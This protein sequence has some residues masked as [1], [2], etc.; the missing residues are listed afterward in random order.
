M[1]N[2]GILVFCVLSSILLIHMLLT[3]S[4][5]AWVRDSEFL[6][7]CKSGTLQEVNDAIIEGA[8]VNARSEERDIT[9]L[10]V[11]AGSNTNS[12]VI[13]A[14]IQA[15]ADI[16]K[17]SNRNETPLM[18][19]AHYNL[20]QKAVAAMI[21]TLYQ[22]GDDVNAKDLDGRTPLLFAVNSTNLQAVLSLLEYGADAT[23]RDH[24]GMRPLDIA[25]TK[26]AFAGT[27]AMRKLREA[28]SVKIIGY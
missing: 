20:D 17:K 21:K 10:I 18:Y 13:T 24:F 15:G 14:L 16:T 11:A 23:V 19:A 9:P 3:S 26:K 5:I 27:E 28:T 8:N 25:V 22:A 1:R 7:I 4:A 6:E 2:K 12:Q